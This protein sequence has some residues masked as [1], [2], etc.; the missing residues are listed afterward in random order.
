METIMNEEDNNLENKNFKFIL[1][2]IFKTL[3][4]TFSSFNFIDSLNVKP[5]ASSLFSSINWGDFKIQ[6]AGYIILMNSVFLDYY[7]MLFYI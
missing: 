6:K 5:L 3:I 7:K 4:Q 2:K 1:N